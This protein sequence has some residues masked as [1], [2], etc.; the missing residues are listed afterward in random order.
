[1][2]REAVVAYFEI[3]FRLCVEVLNKKRAQAGVPI[4]LARTST[5]DRNKTVKSGRM[6]Y[7]GGDKRT[8]RY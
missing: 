4:H 7:K 2:G 3:L 6:Q 5:R 1:M 8:K